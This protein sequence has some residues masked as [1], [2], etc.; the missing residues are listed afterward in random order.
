MANKMIQ[1]G[2]QDNSVTYTHVCDTKADMA[3]IP[4]EQINLG[5]TC[6]VLEGENGDLEFHMA[7]SNKQWVQVA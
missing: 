4:S 5:S 3:N 6:I 7:K 2:N 1:R